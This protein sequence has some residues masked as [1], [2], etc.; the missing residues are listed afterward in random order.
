[1][2]NVAL[3]LGGGWQTLSIPLG[4]EF[5]DVG[6][7]SFRL[8]VYDDS[9]DGTDGLRID[10]FYI[11]G[12]AAGLP[13]G[14][15]QVGIAVTDATAAEP[16]DPASFTLTRGGA[17]A[18]PLDVYYRVTG[19]ASNGVDYATLSGMAT[20]PA[21]SATTVINVNP[22]DDLLQEPTETITLTLFETNG[23]YRIFGADSATATL[24][25]NLEPTQVYVVA[26]DDNAYERVSSLTA[27][28]NLVRGGDTNTAFSVNFTLGGSATPGLD[29]LS[30]ITNTIT[31]A[32]GETVKQVIISPVDDALVEPTEY[33]QLTILSGTGYIT[34]GQTTAQVSVSSDDLSPEAVLFRDDFES[35]DSATN[36]TVLDAA[37]LSAPDSF[38]DYSFDYSTIGVPPAPGSTTTKGLKLTANKTGENRSAAVNLF[39]NLVV[40]TNNFALR[41]NLYLQFVKSNDFAEGALAGINHSGTITNWFNYS[42]PVSLDG[43]GQ[44][45][46]FG[47]NDRD[48]PGTVT[49]FGY[50][51][52]T[53]VPMLLSN[54]THT[55]VASVFNNPPYCAPVVG[56][57]GAL[58]CDANSTTKT[59]VDCELSQVDS[60]V[61]LTVNGVALIAVTNTSVYTQGKV[62]LGYCDAFDS[63]GP[64]ENFAVIDNVRV[65]S[66]PSAPSTPPTIGNISVT[67]QS[68]KVSFSAA[69]DAAASGFKLQSAAIVDGQFADDDTAVI[70][71]SAGAFQATTA[72][73]GAMRFYRIRTN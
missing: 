23:T 2:T 44:Y 49:L 63:T 60:L 59:W 55:T 8:Y 22:I 3:A 46:N 50:N 33:V 12:T 17:T 34:P 61:K 32:A 5:A 57:N 66:L 31:F 27:W 9:N 26:G 62:M 70:T 6:A 18:A 42:S 73:N 64:A 65:V 14:A 16:A 53:N 20:I 24:T 68:V 69:G 36:Y 10:N 1:M 54:R 38:I 58:S 13:P 37:S 21:G 40:S 11:R 67:G 43:D 56:T 51:T 71:G 48:N 7:V 19:S 35:T 52:L 28:F 25:D 4:P 29:Y 39:P 15:Q 72:V 41:F 30:S 47:N 45:V